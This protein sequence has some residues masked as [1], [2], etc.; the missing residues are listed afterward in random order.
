LRSGH[1]RSAEDL[2]DIER[3]ALDEL[4]V[5]IRASFPGVSFRMTL[6]GSRATGDA[7]PESDTDVLIE[8]DKQNIFPF[9]KSGGSGALPGRFL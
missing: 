8:L 1:I 6:F 9:R 7:D 4:K 3:S 2:K 5:R